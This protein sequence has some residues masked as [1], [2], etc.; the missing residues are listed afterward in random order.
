[1]R[2]PSTP[3][4]FFRQDTASVNITTSYIA[5][6]GTTSLKTECTMIYIYNG[7]SSSMKLAIGA[8]GSQVDELLISPSMSINQPFHHS[9]KTEVWIA[10]NATTASSGEVLINFFY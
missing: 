9:A 10:A 4:F 5:V 2:L 7:T 8:S 3:V 6:A 1:M